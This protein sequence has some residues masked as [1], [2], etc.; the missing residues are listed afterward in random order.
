MAARAD[1]GVEDG[2]A[3]D[4]IRLRDG[5]RAVQR[6]LQGEIEEAGGANLRGGLVPNALAGQEECDQQRDAEEPAPGEFERDE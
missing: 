6:E 1:S 3:E 2:R 5:Q 4:L